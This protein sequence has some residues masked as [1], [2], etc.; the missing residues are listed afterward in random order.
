M[1][2]AFLISLLLVFIGIA[3]LIF[4]RLDLARR[5]RPN[6]AHRLLTLVAWILLFVGLLVFMIS[7]MFGFG[8]VLWFFTLATTLMAVLQ[9]RRMEVAALREALA[10]GIREGI[11][12]D[13]ILDSFARDASVTIAWRVDRLRGNLRR[14]RPLAAAC[15]EASLRF[16]VEAEI[17]MR[18]GDELGCLVQLLRQSDTDTDHQ[19]TQLRLISAEFAYVLMSFSVLL[20]SSRF[21]MNNVIPRFQRVFDGDGTQLPVPTLILV[22]LSEWS[23]YY[24]CVSLLFIFLTI[25]ATLVVVVQYVTAFEFSMPILNRIML[26]L[27]GARLLRCL[28]IVV[29]Q[30]QSLSKALDVLVRFYPRRYASAQLRR[31]VEVHGSGQHWSYGLARVGLIGNNDATLLRAAERAGNLPWA[32]TEIAGSIKRRTVRRL[33][34]AVHASLVTVLLGL[35][36]LVLIYC[37]AVYLPLVQ[38]ISGLPV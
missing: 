14:G 26:R 35:G 29:G 27:D 34:A 36:V 23:V 32:M 28:A 2:I 4:L 20:L 8:L 1:H 33:R 25:M 22:K 11:A 24:S 16:D 9:H 13:D 7:V 6:F 37:V 19:A 18:A 21:L 12:L 10:L 38:L 5:S 3:L 31:V 17:A 30:N 15:V